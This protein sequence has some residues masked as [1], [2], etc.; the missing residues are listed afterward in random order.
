MIPY[1]TKTL[2]LEK[3]MDSKE[4]PIEKRHK[5]TNDNTWGQTS[6]ALSEPQRCK[7]VEK[8]MASPRQTLSILNEYGKSMLRVCLE[9]GKSMPR[10]CLEYG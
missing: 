10:V 6:C 1:K 3:D 9:Y 2:S 5:N 7:G 8:E 4:F